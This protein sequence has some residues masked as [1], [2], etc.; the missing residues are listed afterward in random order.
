M[1]WFVAA[2]AAYELVWSLVAV[3]RP[4]GPVFALVVSAFVVVD[5]GGFM[6]RQGDRR[7][8]ETGRTLVR[9]ASP[10]FDT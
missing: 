4:L 1:L 8:R 5:P 7:A 3:P 9:V 6:W 2:L 10:T